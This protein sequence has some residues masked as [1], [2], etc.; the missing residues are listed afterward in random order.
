PWRGNF[1]GLGPP[2]AFDSGMVLAPT[3]P[4]CT[5]TQLIF[6]YGGFDLQHWQ[7]MQGPWSSAIGR[8]FMRRDGF[9]SWDNLPGRTGIVETQPLLVSGEDLWLNADAR[10]GQVRVEVRDEGGQVIPGFTQADCTPLREDTARYPQCLAAIRWGERKLGELAGRRV[11][12]RFS[13]E[14]T[15]LFALRLGEG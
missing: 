2:G 12:L 10:A 9:A 14:D 6:Y 1:I 7:P 11:R 8:A 3:D 15:A 4:I 5:E 13:L